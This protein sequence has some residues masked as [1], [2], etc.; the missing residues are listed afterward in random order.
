MN[1]ESQIQETQQMRIVKHPHSSLS[2]M[3]RPVREDELKEVTLLAEEA[4][5]LMKANNGLGLAANQ[6]DDQRRWFVLLG[7]GLIINP[8]WK[9]T[10]SSKVKNTSEGCLSMPG[11][12][13]KMRRNRIIRAEWT[14]SEGYKCGKVL[15]GIQ[16]IAFQHE[17]DH[18]NGVNIWDEVARV[19]R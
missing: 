19:K 15:R 5:G 17:T 11:R 1:E 12:M 8:T 14:D 6:V 7:F 16:S 13:F 3:S 4:T 18:L 2:T 10:A 9:P